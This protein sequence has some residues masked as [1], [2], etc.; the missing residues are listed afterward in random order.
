MSCDCAAVCS[1]QSDQEWLSSDEAGHLL[2]DEKPAL[3][4]RHTDDSARNDSV[5]ENKRFSYKVNEVLFDSAENDDIQVAHERNDVDVDDN[6]DD[7]MMVAAAEERSWWDAFGAGSDVD[8]V[9][10]VVEDVTDDVDVAPTDVSKPKAA[11]PNMDNAGDYL[12]FDYQADDQWGWLIPDVCAYQNIPHTHAHHFVGKKICIAT[13][14]LRNVFKLECVFVECN[15]K[16][17]CLCISFKYLY[18]TYE[19]YFR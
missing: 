14:I 17:T 8:D 6:V 3:E 4:R 11:K 5:L 13:H 19:K 18:V 10:D 12:G 9:I 2:D 7:V 1:S 16:C 15:G